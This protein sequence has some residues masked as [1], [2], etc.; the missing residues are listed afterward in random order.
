MAV[1]G[2]ASRPGYFSPEDR[3]PA[4]TGQE[5]V[6]APPP[7]RRSW[8]YGW[9]KVPDLP[10][11]ELC[12]F[13]PRFS[14]YIDWFLRKEMLLL[15]NKQ[16]WTARRTL[17]YGQTAE[18]ARRRQQR[19][20][21]EQFLCRHSVRGTESPVARKFTFKTPFPFNKSRFHTIHHLINVYG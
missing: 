16:V 14:H 11:I 6:C 1:S 21:C 3:I 8:R 13:S 2:L 17:R 12:S 19:G 10:G 9:K 15:R 5:S 20:N 4:P 18:R 7:P